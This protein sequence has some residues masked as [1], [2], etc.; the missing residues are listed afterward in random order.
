MSSAVLSLRSPAPHSVSLNVQIPQEPQYSQQNQVEILSNCSKQLTRS[1]RA[2]APNPSKA[3]SSRRLH[4]L[5]FDTYAS[6]KKNRRLSTVLPEPPALEHSF[7]PSEQPHSPL[8]SPLIPGIAV[9]D[10]HETDSSD[11]ENN[12]Q[13]G[14]G[15]SFRSQV[16]PSKHAP[17]SSMKAQYRHKDMEAAALNAELDALDEELLPTKARLAANP[18]PPV[19][20]LPPSQG[21]SANAPAPTAAPSHGHTPAPSAASLLAPP[22]KPRRVPMQAAAPVECPRLPPVMPPL[23]ITPAQQP[24]PPTAHA[25]RPAEHHRSRSRSRTPMLSIPPAVLPALEPS[26]QIVPAEKFQGTYD[27]FV[28]QG[29]FTAIALPSPPSQWGASHRC[30]SPINEVDEAAKQEILD[31][32]EADMDIEEDVGASV[33]RRT[34][35][36]RT[37]MEDTFKDIRKQL[38][39]CATALGISYDALLK[40]FVQREQAIPRTCSTWNFYQRYANHSDQTRH[41]ERQRIVPED[42][43]TTDVPALKPAELAKAYPLFVKSLGGEEEASTFLS[44]FFDAGGFSDDTLQ[45]RGHRYQGAVRCYEKL[46]VRHRTD[47]FFVHVVIV[48]AHTNEDTK[49]GQIVCTPGIEEFLSQELNTTEDE[50]I[51]FLKVRAA[52]V[53]IDDQSALRREQKAKQ[54]KGAS[55]APTSIVNKRKRTSKTPSTS[56]AG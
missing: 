6:V 27:E 47:N 1:K 14:G 24:L 9:F 25:Q 46:A 18:L 5:I 43:T 26:S 53:L 39:Q 52:G 2:K 56:A 4:I 44:K 15:Y 13:V 31:D 33:G 21:S 30:P 11:N 32:P 37:H 38:S 49:L 22:P 16:T 48:G 36:E 10:Q 42:R 50:I 23:R 19:Y 55:S 40:Q 29:G 41:L 51:G 54:A 20:A 17:P 34:A 12:E 7:S 3:L 8:A 45:E 35:D 28:T